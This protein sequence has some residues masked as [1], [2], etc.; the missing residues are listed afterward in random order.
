MIAVRVVD[1]TT[2]GEL[3]AAGELQFSTPVVTLRDL[4]A[5]RVKQELASLNLEVRLAPDSR[6][7]TE[8]LLNG[9]VRHATLG[10]DLETQV[11]RALRSFESNG[12][13]VIARDR[14]LTDLDECLDV[15]ELREVRFLRLTPLI[16]G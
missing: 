15:G 8:R 11:Q 5:E 4:I 9:P 14:Q 2:S 6:T 7:E 1:E 3:E 10:I 13:L 12:F 16:G